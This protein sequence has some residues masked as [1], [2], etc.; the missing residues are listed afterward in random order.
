MA[1]KRKAKKA[2]K[3]DLHVFDEL[4]AE[5]N[6]L[7]AD[8]TPLL[9]RVAEAVREACVETADASDEVSRR[10]AGDLRDL[11]LAAVVAK[12]VGA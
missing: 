10:V 1:T 5:V 4:R 3:L 8:S 6:A 2:K 7:R 12:V 9:M 11:N